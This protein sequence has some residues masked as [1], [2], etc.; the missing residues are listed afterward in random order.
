MKRR[1]AMR[2]AAM[3]AAVFSFSGPVF[4]FQAQKLNSQRKPVSFKNGVHSAA[5]PDGTWNLWVRPDPR[6]INILSVRLQL[7]VAEDEQFNS[8]VSREVL[9]A[10][11]KSGYIVKT[12]FK[13]PTSR[14]PLYFRYLV[15]PTNKLQYGQD[16]Q[17]SPI[18]T[19]KPFS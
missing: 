18:G 11:R 1:E 8:L 5:L 4:A 9:V 3:I 14:R 17:V 16:V 2:K 10:H 15:L 19:M 7:E 6:D 12:N 13:N